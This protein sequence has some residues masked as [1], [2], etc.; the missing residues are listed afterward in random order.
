MD[1]PKST[2]GGTWSATYGRYED[3]AARGPALSLWPS[4]PMARDKHVLERYRSFGIPPGTSSTYTL[5][6]ILDSYAWRPAP[7]VQ[8]QL[9]QHKIM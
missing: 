4:L 8:A 1:K 2:V 6:S 9:G 7:L 5:G 3:T